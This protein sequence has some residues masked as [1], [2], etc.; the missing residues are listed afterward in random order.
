MM[1]E[2]NSKSCRLMIDTADQNITDPHLSDSVRKVAKHL[3]YVHISDN[4]G[5]GEGLVHNVPGKGT[6]NWRMFIRVLK[7]VGYNG[8]LTAQ[9]NCGVPIDPDAWVWETYEYMSRLI[10]ESKG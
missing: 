3:V 10:Q 6:I 9:L 4:S 1:K 2:I 5:S 8:Y 7:E